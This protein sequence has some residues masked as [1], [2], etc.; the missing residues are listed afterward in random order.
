MDYK[1]LN[2]EHF[3]LTEGDFCGREAVLVTPAHSD[4]GWTRDNLSYRSIVF[5]KN[6]NEVLSHSFPKFFNEGQSPEL[7]PNPLDFDD[8]AIYE[9]ID[10]STLILDL[11]DGHV[12]M[13]T[14]GILNYKTQL[15][16]ADFTLL[17]I[18]YPGVER[19][20]KLGGNFYTLLFEIVTP[21]NKIVIDYGSEVDF[22][23]IG[24]IAKNSGEICDEFMLDS[25]ARTY[26]LKRPRKYDFKDMDDLKSIVKAWK[27]DEGVVITY[28][29]GQ[30]KIKVK[31]DR[32]CFLH[33]IMSGLLS[34][35]DIVDKFISLNYINREDFFNWYLTEFDYEIAVML[36]DS[37]NDVCDRYNKLREK[38][39]KVEQFV[40]KI[41]KGFSRREQAEE[42]MLNYSDWRRGHAFSTLDG[43]PADKNMMKKLLL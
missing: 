32:Y 2:P 31:A 20:L 41:D 6:T 15:N 27:T 1:T 9:K 33:S 17:F 30:N 26:S 35:K 7:Y 4:A 39:E 25:L 22:Y 24:S 13:R 19:L 40:D 23:F 16:F 36:R 29:E 21:N 18:K 37:I 11:V 8:W 10:G 12:S 28:N 14:R 34:K 38:M 42:I 3:N 5:D 43:K